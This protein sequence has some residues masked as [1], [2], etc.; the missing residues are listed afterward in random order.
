MVWIGG[1]LPVMFWDDLLVAASRVQQTK[2]SLTLWPL[3]MEL[4][5]SQNVSN[6]LPIYAV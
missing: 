3:K 4:I 1:F 2:S 5:L 6:K